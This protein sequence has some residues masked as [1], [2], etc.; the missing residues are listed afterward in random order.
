MGIDWVPKLI[1]QE[2]GGYGQ[3]QDHDLMYSLQILLNLGHII[4]RKNMNE[5]K[6]IHS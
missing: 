3:E 6:N 5:F 2:R 1:I 4:S